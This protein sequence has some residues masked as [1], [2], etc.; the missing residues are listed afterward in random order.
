VETA[1]EVALILQQTID[2]VENVKLVNDNVKVVD[3]RMQTIA[4]GRQRLF[5]ESAASSLI[6]IIQTARQ[7]PRK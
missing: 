5:S 6:L 7:P 4:D 1:K 2:G 3:G